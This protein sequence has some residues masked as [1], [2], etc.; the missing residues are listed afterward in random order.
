MLSQNGENIS[1][2]TKPNTVPATSAHMSILSTYPPYRYSTEAN[3]V[4]SPTE[5]LCKTRHRYH[6]TYCVVL[7]RLNTFFFSNFFF[8]YITL[9]LYEYL[10]PRD[11]KHADTA[12]WP[13][14]YIPSSLSHLLYTGNR[15]TVWK[16]TSTFPHN[17]RRICK[18]SNP[19]ALPPPV[20][21]TPGYIQ[22]MYLSWRWAS[23]VACSEMNHPE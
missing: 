16:V 22:C 13:V 14:L 15:P 10:T 2:P 17:K 5:P 1:E 18:P 8:S 7:K 11:P 23:D 3:S 4:P 19:P 12:D 20:R 21:I 9:R 6:R